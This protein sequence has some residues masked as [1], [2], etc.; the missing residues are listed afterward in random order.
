MWPEEEMM[1]YPS[2]FPAISLPYYTV[3]AL[4]PEC[5]TSLYT[6]TLYLIEAGKKRPL[7]SHYKE[8]YE[9]EGLLP[10]EELV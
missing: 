4:A 9:R 10:V 2:L 7:F 8:K 3:Y 6:L 5:P 1:A